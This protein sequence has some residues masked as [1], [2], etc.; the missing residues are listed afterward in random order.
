EG[1]GIEARRSNN[2]TSASITHPFASPIANV[3]AIEPAMTRVMDDGD[4][5]AGV[6]STLRTG[7]FAIIALQIGYTVL[8]RL[9]Y[10][11]NFA[12][13][14]PFHLA[15]VTLGLIALATALSPRAMRNW[16]AISLLVFTAI[17]ASTAFMTVI[18]GDCD[19]LV[20]SIVLFS[21]G[22]GAMLPWSPRWQAALEVGGAIAMI[23]YSMHTADTTLSVANDWTTVVGALVLSQI[24]AIR[25]ARN[26]QKLAE[27]LA[28]LA[29]NHRL[30]VREMDLR[31]EV[32]AA[33]E[34][35]HI[36][37]QTSETML[38][39]VFD[40]SPDSIAIN[41]LTDGRFV[42]VNDNYQVAGYTRGDVMGTDVIALGMWPDAQEMTRFLESIQR[43]GRV[44]NMEI[45]QRRK[46]GRL[47]TNLISASVI[48][49]EGEPCVISMTRDI[50]EIKQ[51]ETSLRASHAALRKIFDATLD[52]IVVTRLSDGAYV[53]FNQ[54]FERFGYGQKDLD[55]SRKG[56]RQIWASEDQHQQLRARILA[57]GVIRNMEVDFVL[58]DGRLM[59]GLLAAV[60][61]ELEGEDCVVTMIRDLTAS[62]EASRKLEQSV[63]A[64]SDSEETFRKLFDVNLDSMTLT[65]P[66]GIYLDVNQEF[67][68]A[69]G[70]SREEAIGRHFADLNMW[71]HQDEMV[72]FADH[73][74]RT[75]E[76]RNLE[77]AFRRKDGIETPV[78]LSAV[79]LE[80]HGQL[81]C[82]T[83]SREISDLKMTQ[84]ELV[85]AREAALAA[86][87]AK[88]E[89]L[90]SM[91]HE[92]R[93][94]MNSILGMSDLLMETALDDEQRRYLSTVIRN[95]HALLALINSILDLAK[96]ESGR[97]SLEAVEF[98]LKDV[99]EKVLETLAIRA[100]EK[101]LE[102]M[103]RFA[104]EVPE[105]ALGDPLRLGQILINLIGNA[106]K[107][108]HKGQVL[109]SVGHDPA[110][111]SAGGLKFSVTDTGIG[112]AADKLPLLF[113]AFS[114]ADSSTSRK[115]GGSGLG[116]AI[117]SR[118]VALMHGKVAVSSEP[119]TG[120][121]FSFTAQFGTATAPGSSGSRDREF[122]DVRIL[123]A[124]DNGDSRSIVAE[125]LIARGAQVTQAS[126]ATD[127]IAELRTDRGRQSRFQVVLLDGTMV[128]T[129]GFDAAEYLMSGAASARPRLVMMLGTNDLTLEVGRLRALGI[130]NYIVKPVR[131]AELF[132][133]VARARAGSQLEARADVSATPATAAASISSAT[134]DR[135]LNILMADDS[136]D[137]RSLIRAYLRKT[138]YH[139]VEANDGQQAIDKFIAGKFDLVL[140]DIQMP[141][142]D[143]YEATSTI[144]V[145]EAANSRHRTPIVALTASALEDAAHRTRA[146]GCDAHVTKP[147]KKSTL[148][149]AIRN[150]IETNKFEEPHAQVAALKEEPCRT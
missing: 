74:S 101:G 133:A 92:I 20:A 7:A 147:V 107:F 53:D 27:Q 17:I 71:I 141:I 50:T 56:Q 29:R 48:E 14:S 1:L 81:C 150:A 33:R 39:K 119:G 15:N 44:K 4:D 112:I 18:D 126:S 26:R 25:G 49:V 104:P 72:A 10:P 144:R 64:L 80:L 109:L 19:P 136:Q 36:Q 124:D 100:H 42:A 22:A 140:M 143:G 45:A 127:A 68:R 116:L 35:D 132:A 129:G 51:V 67:T 34:R 57:E 130:D 21:F 58:P 32:A 76:A 128:T 54:Q 41:S 110:S 131:R 13:T 31:A 16:R 106:I 118:L 103:V 30:L 24:T 90:S 8:G 88:S 43:T 86:S 62:K 82:L 89:F 23:G 97:L 121:E 138:P 59:P 94:P 61:V 123:L 70:F 55:D 5:L 83:I 102:L 65:G 37:L 115:Y 75:G 3:T 85:A 149:E 84:R 46:D 96:V 146:A 125:L 93:T 78:L 79:F 73:L 28:A 87:R 11:H 6:S 134:I 98:D 148:L 47:E 9:V 114:Q 95:S 113:D 99:T 139:L 108:T 142:V 122:A 40:A 2:G 111:T 69:T 66:D 135:P 145:W 52:I 117:V 38:R 120:S 60:R 137:N 77:V 63:K 12:S 105:L 91:S